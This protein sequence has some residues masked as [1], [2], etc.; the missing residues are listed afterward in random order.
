MVTPKQESTL[1]A[2]KFLL[3]SQKERRHGIPI[4]NPELILAMA[5]IRET[6]HA[7]LKLLAESL[8]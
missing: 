6:H 4:M 7:K 5:L 3:G 1:D 8:E 2:R